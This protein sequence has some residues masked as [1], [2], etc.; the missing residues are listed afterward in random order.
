MIK[1][2]ETH[3]V[4]LFIDRDTVTYFDSLEIKYVLQEM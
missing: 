1:G 2:K 3:W 4:S